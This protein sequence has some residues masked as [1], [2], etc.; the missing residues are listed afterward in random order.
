MK[1]WSLMSEA[2]VVPSYLATKKYL[3]AWD[4]SSPRGLVQRTMAA[5][6]GCIGVGAS[7]QECLYGPCVAVVSCKKDGRLFDK[8]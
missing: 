7:C 6:V 1:L 3:N 4:M 5:K 2:L 8:K